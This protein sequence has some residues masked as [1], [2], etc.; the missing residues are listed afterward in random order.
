MREIED[1]FRIPISINIPD[2]YSLA[3]RQ[4]SSETGKS[5]IDICYTLSFFRD[6]FPRATEIVRSFMQ[7]V[8]HIYTMSALMC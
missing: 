5:V 7:G 6:F 2:L 3:D 1:S 4:A 8:I